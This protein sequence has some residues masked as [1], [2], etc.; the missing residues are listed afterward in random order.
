MNAQDKNRA[1]VVKSIRYGDNSLIVKLLTENNGL[2]SFLV[3]GAFNKTAKIR[4]ALFQ[5]L[6]I[7]EIVCARSR[8]DLGFL[9]EATVSHAFQSIPF[10]MKKN[11]IV[12]F[13]SELLSKTIQDSE[14]D[15]E[16]FGFI[17]DSL[18][19][20]DEVSEKYA[21]FPLKFAIELSRHLG[22]SPNT[23]GFR[24]GGV[25]N[26]EDG[27]FH[28]D[29][30]GLLYIIDNQLSEKFF[31]LCNSNFF[32]NQSLEIGNNERRALLESVMTYFK[33]HV[34]GFNEMKSYEIL[35]IVLSSFGEGFKH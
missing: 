26:L 21:D 14:P 30:V 19:Y 35:R 6:T 15:T 1:I 10:E 8:G 28:H 20:L 34:A 12:M 33:L 25:F 16:L 32:D 5:P 22:F 3:K 7:L 2:Q 27:C 4:A 13:V 29:G 31:R 11:A 18:V 9:K 23:N 24:N 17:H